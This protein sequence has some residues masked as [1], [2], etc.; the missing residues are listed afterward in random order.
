MLSNS[1]DNTVVANIAKTESLISIKDINNNNN[2][3]KNNINDNNN[4][5]NNQNNDNIENM[6]I[7]EKV[8]ETETKSYNISNLKDILSQHNLLEKHLNE[9]KKKNIE[10]IYNEN[11]MYI[12][13]FHD[14]YN[15]NINGD[16]SKDLELI[17]LEKK[18]YIY[19]NSTESIEDY[20]RPLINVSKEYDIQKL[21]EE[22]LYNQKNKTGSYGLNSEYDKDTDI[23]PK[24]YLK[25]NIFNVLMPGIQELLSNVKKSEEGLEKEIKDP[26]NWLA[27][28]LKNNN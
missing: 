25:K 4:N 15:T 11:K 20:N 26:I 16:N 13:Y 9:L 10:S 27:N 3:M 12:D 2:N 28:Y 23:N 22:E 17:K 6:N 18:K 19:F 21:K 14:K 7:N 8:T 1:L 5:N 24:E